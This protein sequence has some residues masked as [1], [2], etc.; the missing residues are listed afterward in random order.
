MSCSAKLT[1]YAFFTAAFF[2]EN[3]VPVVIGLYLIGI[4]VGV[5]FSLVMRIFIFKGNPVPFIMELPNYRFPSLVNI[6]RL[7]YMK[8][9]NFVTQAFSIIFFATIVVWFLQAFDVKLDLVDNP[10]DSMLADLG[11]FLSPIFAPLGISDWR[12]S[13]AFISGFIA[14]ESVI[15][16][17]TVL[18]GGDVSQLPSCFSQLTAF[19]FLVFSLLYTPCVAT[20]AAVKKELGKRYALGIILVQCATAWVVSFLVYQVGKLVC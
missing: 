13:T 19:V 2:K 20:I 1:I 17:F 10:A 11:G 5:I 7:I 6:R 8:A 16:T 9:K 18:L 3:Q 14:K 15:S 4:I 12:I